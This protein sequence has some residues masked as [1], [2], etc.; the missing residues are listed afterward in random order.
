[1][2]FGWSS[3]TYVIKCKPYL[4]TEEY[5]DISS[6]FYVTKIKLGCTKKH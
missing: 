1:M 4:N 6:Y 3:M 2:K 5:S